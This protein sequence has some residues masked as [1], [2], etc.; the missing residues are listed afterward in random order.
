MIRELQLKPD[1]ARTIERF[2]AWWLGELIDRPPV[3]L[4]VLPTRP[5]QGPVS[6]H[7]TQRARWLDV[8]FVVDAAIANMERTDYVGDHFPLFWPNVGPEI[9]ATLWGCDL[10]FTETT[11]WSKPVIHRCE[12]WQR[13]LATPPDF[14]NPYWQTI[15]RMT[16]YALQCNEGRYVVGLTDLHGNYDILAALRDPM[17]LCLDL[18]DC[19]ELVGQAGRHVA[20]GYVA[21]FE[22]LYAKVAAA[23]FGTTTWM[24]MYHEGRAYA[25]SSDFWCMV[26][27]Q[28][29]RDL[30]L[31]DILVEIAPLERS[32]FHLDGP[33]ALRHLDLLLDLPQLNALQWV[34]GAG[35]GPAVRWVETYQR[36]RQAHKS[37]Q[38]IARDPADAL[39]VLEQ[40]GP[41]GVWVHVEQPFA[42]VE[43][44]NTFI[45]NVE[46]YS[47]STQNIYM[48]TT[49]SHL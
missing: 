5:Y 31:P 47:R 2:A 34:Y 3:T 1:F 12:D 6:T 46:Q 4:T 14:A 23:G 19:P 48:Q 37:L 25:P 16:D 9:T 29:A 24:A 20:N 21:S 33:T 49:V 28:V 35:R 15:E 26:S 17:Q 39:A 8:E 41:A 45:G 36:I 11:S 30:I 40:I 27:E 18:M 44:A 10:S 32:I 38:L 22:R 7:A 43:E 42:S 13:L